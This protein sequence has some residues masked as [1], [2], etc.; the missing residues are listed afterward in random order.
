MSLAYINGTFPYRFMDAANGTVTDEWGGNITLADSKPNPERM[1]FTFN[2][3]YASTL[4]TVGTS[5]TF[6]PASGSVASSFLPVE[7][8]I[9]WDD[10]FNNVKGI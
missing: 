6:T 1:S 4:G 5:Y 7:Q 3:T 10:R 9:Y 2:N 8:R